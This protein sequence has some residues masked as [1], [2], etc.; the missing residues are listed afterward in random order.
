MQKKTTRMAVVV[1][2]AALGL[3]A[4]GKS[5][6]EQKSAAV[7]QQELVN[8]INAYL[9]T[10]EKTC[11]AVPVRFGEPVEEKYEALTQPNGAQLAAL[12]KAGL[13]QAGPVEGEAGKV[14]FTVTEDG[15]NFYT[16]LTEPAGPGF[17]SGTLEVEKIAEDKVVEETSN[18]SRHNVGYTYKIANP[19]PWQTNADVEAQF[20]KF[21]ELVK[22]VGTAK[23]TSDLENRGKGWNVVE[24]SEFS[25]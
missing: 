25:N 16:G 21:A 8:S 11:I 15:T 1:A 13:I 18:Y 7:D 20:P 3:A 14:Q 24:S 10:A 2:L 9:S 23:L 5:G 19:A 12:V 6:E 4:C 17:C 22:G